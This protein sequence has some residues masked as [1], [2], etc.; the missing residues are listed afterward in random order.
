VAFLRELKV[1]PSEVLPRAKKMADAAGHQ[2]TGLD[3]IAAAGIGETFKGWVEEY[4][5]S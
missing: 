5:A 1:K 4:A 3:G 2:L